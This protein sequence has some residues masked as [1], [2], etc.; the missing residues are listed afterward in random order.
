MRDK[1]KTEPEKSPEQEALEKRVDAMMDPKKPDIP[2]A[3]ITPKPA[4]TKP[5][6]A[7][8]AVTSPVPDGPTTAP[9]LPKPGKKITITDTPNKPLSIDKLDE[10]AASIVDSKSK[11]HGKLAQPKA[12]APKTQDKSQ[13][14]EK[15]E[16][17]E[18]PEEPETEPAEIAMEDDITEQSAELEDPQT[19]KA[20]D[21]IVAY[22]GDVILAV[23]DSTA[24][25]HNRE[26]A[27]SEPREH[28]VFSVL[29]WTL[30]ALVAILAIALTA[31]L[32]MGDSLADKLGL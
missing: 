19:D 31:L 1:K 28:H 22:E 26:F 11:K 16:E 32:V 2:M 27:D 20:V 18:L 13:E 8:Q 24:A 15:E 9:Q 6:P 10:L 17:S 3:E 23:A 4:A 25:E 29:I 5:K 14:P 7:I 12:A 21:D 30:V